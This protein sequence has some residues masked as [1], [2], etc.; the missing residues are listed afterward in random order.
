VF[1]YHLFCCFQQRPPSH[2]RGSC[3]ARG[4]GQLWEHLGQALQKLGRSDV[5]MAA[6]GCLG[7]CQAGP[8]M[9]V[10]PEGVWYRCQTTQDVDEILRS[11]VG[12]GKIVEH[13]AVVLK[14]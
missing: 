9:V 13:L 3:G 14:P 1:R 2:P 10:Y 11:H 8:L 4:A 7:F 5:A 12:E 6:T